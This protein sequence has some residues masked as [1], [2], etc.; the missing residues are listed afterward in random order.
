[1]KFVNC[2][3]CE[4]RRKW[5]HDR[6]K[7]SISSIPRAIEALSSVDFA[8]R[9]VLLAR[10]PTSQLVIEY[11]GNISCS[12]Y[13]VTTDTHSKRDLFLITEKS[14]RAESS[15]TAINYTDQYYLNAKDYV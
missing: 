9:G 11:E 5:L 2:Q 1:M 8:E 13:L 3:G 7:Q 6:A 14:G 4:Q 12:T 15:V 10:T